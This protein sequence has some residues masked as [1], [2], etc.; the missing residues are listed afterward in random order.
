MRPT[1]SASIPR[2]QERDIQSM[3]ALG[4]RRRQKVPPA[5]TDVLTFPVQVKTDDVI[6]SL[7]NAGDT[8]TK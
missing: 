4:Y 6:Q 1:Y 7:R 8:V 5:P 2:E 3:V